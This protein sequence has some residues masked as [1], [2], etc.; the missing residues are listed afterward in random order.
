ME[1]DRNKACK[2]Y[3][4]SLSSEHPALLGTFVVNNVY[5]KIVLYRRTSQHG[6]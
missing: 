1:R 4:I 6:F 3:A 2:T 5:I